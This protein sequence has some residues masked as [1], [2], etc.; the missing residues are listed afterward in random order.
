[1]QSSL[2]R[3][4]II[5][6]ISRFTPVLSLDSLFLQDAKSGTGWNGK[7]GK[8]ARICEIVSTSLRAA[9]AFSDQTIFL[10]GIL[11]ADFPGR[12]R[13]EYRP[14][15]PRVTRSSSYIIPGIW[16]ASFELLY[17]FEILF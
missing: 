1:M 8:S 12:N 3:R 9:L 14:P 15:H 5:S 11:G 7:A 10:N 13:T 4:D 2:H 17:G 6:P 16:V